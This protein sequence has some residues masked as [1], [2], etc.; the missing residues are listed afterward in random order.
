MTANR[1][2]SRALAAVRVRCRAAPSLIAHASGAVARLA[3]GPLAGRTL[4]ATALAFALVSLAGCRTA[5]AQTEPEPRPVRIETVRAA[6][7]E[8]AVRYSA[9]IAPHSQVPVAFKVGGYIASILQRPGAD[10][11]PRDVQQG[12]VVKQGTVLAQVSPADYSARLDQS[13]AGV[14][15]AE[16]A[17][18]K[19]QADFERAST[20]FASKSLTKPEL[21]SARAALDSAKS[22]LDAT[23]AEARLAAISLRDTELMMP[24][25]GI[26]LERR[27]ERGALVAPGSVGFV[28]GNMRS[29]KAVFGVPD[30]IAPQMTLGSPVPIR[31]D[32]L[33]AREFPGRVTAVSPAADP[34]SR[35]FSIEVTVPNR[36]EALRP[37]M[38]ATVEVRHAT[39][40]RTG[41]TPAVPL[42]AVVKQPP[43]SQSASAASQSAP[44]GQPASS[45]QAGQPGQSTD[46]AVFVIEDSGG[47]TIAR[48]RPIVL[49][50]VAGNTVAVNSGLRI[51]ERVIVSGATLVR[52]GERVRIVP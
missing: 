14:S 8:P 18:V 30:V 12:D 3:F 10:R 9:N 41:S 27:I 38:V 50:D 21:D 25:N 37:G 47:K 49:G 20:L 17:A 34:Q 46:Y 5:P 43:A 24:L 7:G 32:A 52:D 19:A 33:P 22:R 29:V 16:A 4:R 6:P 2:H 13:R 35:V 51:G 15:G 1:P 28:V 48:L 39:S 44:A 42:A 36:D 31:T 11:Q 26:V 23:Q 40:T 45:S